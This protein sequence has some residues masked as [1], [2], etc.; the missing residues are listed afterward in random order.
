MSPTQAKV[1]H[2]AL[3][4]HST[5][6]SETVSDLDFPQNPFH[7]IRSRLLRLCNS[8]CTMR[9]CKYTK[10]GWRKMDLMVVVIPVATFGLHCFAWVD[11]YS[12]RSANT[13]NNHFHCWYIKS[14]WHITDYLRSFLALHA[15]FQHSFL[16]ENWS[17][18]EAPKNPLWA[19][20]RGVVAL[21]GRA[22]QRLMESS[23]WTKN[24]W[25]SHNEVFVNC[26]LPF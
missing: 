14:N 4:H 5:F 3:E 24:T 16:K 1:D 23:K 11:R 2:Q 12:V 22:T 18:S 25:E 15:C 6:G 19:R 26:R 10:C 20:T 13:R 17:Y 9:T 7:W 8:A 21:W